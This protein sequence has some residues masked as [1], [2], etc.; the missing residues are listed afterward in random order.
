MACSFNVLIG[1]IGAVVIDHS[2]IIDSNNRTEYVTV[3]CLT[4]NL[5]ETTGERAIIYKKVEPHPLYPTKKIY[6]Y[7]LIGDGK[8]SVNKYYSPDNGATSFMVD[9][10]YACDIDE[11]TAV[12]M[13][14]NVVLDKESFLHPQNLIDTEFALHTATGSTNIPLGIFQHYTEVGTKLTNEITDGNPTFG[15]PSW[16]KNKRLYTNVISDQYSAICSGFYNDTLFPFYNILLNHGYPETAFPAVN[17]LLN[18]SCNLWKQNGKVD[19]MGRK[20]SK[21]I[22]TSSDVINTVNKEN[23]NTY[24]LPRNSGALSHIT[25]NMFAPYNKRT[26]FYMEN[27]EA[28]YTNSEGNPYNLYTSAEYDYNTFL[29]DLGDDYI[30]T[31]IYIT[32]D[33]EGAKKY[34]ETGELPSDAK[35]IDDLDTE[36][37]TDEEETKNEDGKDNSHRDEQENNDPTNTASNSGATNYYYMTQSGLENFIKWFWN[38]TGDL[39]DLLNNWFSNVYGDMKECITGVYHFPCPLTALASTTAQKKIFIGRYDTGLTSGCLVNP[40]KNILLGSVNLND[41]QW[42]NTDSFLDFDGYTT[43]SL[44]LPYYGLVDLPTKTV[45]YT[46]ISVYYAVDVPSMQLLYTVKSNGMIV[47]ET[48][49]SFGDIVPISLSSGIQNAT[50]TMNMA[51]NIA[52]SAGAIGLGV[53]TGGAAVPLIAGGVLSTVASA[54]NQTDGITV[55]GNATGQMGK[56]S[57]LKCALI[58]TKPISKRPKNYGK[59]KGNLICDDY[60]LSSLK[61][62]GLTI[63]ENP[64][65]KFSLTKPTLAEIDEIYDYLKKGVIL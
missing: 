34:V 46:T 30:F 37:K 11:T 64:R 2:E 48:S 6:S 5:I 35:K 10:K 47:F 12:N 18:K 21:T 56:W 58:V 44:Y 25:D 32:E 40:P 60:K 55:K 62:K 15:Y 51:T 33:Y 22:I 3:S 50:N 45:M 57:S 8:I 65:L 20:L 17:L 54:H 16:L 52:T 1:K 14:L 31:G 39:E 49:I 24:I 38:N 23:P 26:D 42:K 53:A 27:F 13:G 59:I 9:G 19:L 61:G 41:D 43:I 4:N 29:T 63:C 7:H 28:L 36:P